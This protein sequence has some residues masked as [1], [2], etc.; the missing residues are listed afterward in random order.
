MKTNRLSEQFGYK[1]SSRFKDLME[2]SG[3]EL[4]FAEVD[5]H[6]MVDKSGHLLTLENINKTN[7]LS[8][9]SPSWNWVLI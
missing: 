8:P 3:L 9:F 5:I 7:E 1:T 4:F 6:S 2:T